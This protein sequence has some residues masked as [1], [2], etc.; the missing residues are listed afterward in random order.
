MGSM[1]QAVWHV[2]H[3]AGSVIWDLCCS[4]TWDLCCR[5]CDMGAMQAMPVWRGRGRILRR[6]AVVLQGV[7]ARFIDTVFSVYF[8]IGF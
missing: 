1:L 2:I 8:T 3:D 4:V 7:V 5:Q 6:S